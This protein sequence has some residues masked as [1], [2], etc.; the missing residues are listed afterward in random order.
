MSL[1]DGLAIWHHLK[2]ISTF[3][4]IVNV[5]TAKQNR[6]NPNHLVI[7]N[8][9][10]KTAST[11]VWNMIYKLS[12]IHKFLYAHVPIRHYF[13]VRKIEFGN[14]LYISHIFKGHVFWRGDIFAPSLQHTLA[15]FYR[16]AH[17]VHWQRSPRP[18]GYGKAKLDQR[19]TRSHW[20]TRVWILLQ[21]AS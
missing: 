6:S 13:Q 19:C 7:Y 15:L 17:H 1:S 16:P 11:T 8:R 21:E 4:R 5:P 18:S 10:P 3:R 20:E 14:F 2:V 9:V 12:F